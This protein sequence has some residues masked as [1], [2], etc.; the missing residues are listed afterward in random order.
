M[1]ANSYT[2]YMFDLVRRVVDEIGP[3]PP[4]SEEEKRL[5]RL[6]VD[7]WKPICHSVEVETF[8]CSPHAFLGFL[9]FSV[10]CY[11]VAVVLYWFYPPV[12]FA[13]AAIGIG[14][15]LLQLNYREFVDP[16]F[17][18]RQGENVIGAVRPEGEPGRRVIVCA[19]QDSAYEFN[20]FYYL[21]RAA[22]PVGLVA[23]VAVVIMLGGSLAKTVAYFGGSADATV[24]AV[25]G[26]VTVGLSPVVALFAFFHTY[27]PVPGA[28]DD[29]SGLAVMAGLGKYLDEAK[30]NG[31]W[32][33]ER[34]EVVLL[35]TS[36]EE[37]GLRGAKRY[38]TR[39]LEE[40][41]ATPTYGLFLECIYDEKFLTVAH[42]EIFTGAKHDPGLVRMAREVAAAHNWPIAVKAIPVGASDASAF[43]A[44][45]IPSICLL[46]QDISRP[47]PNYHTRNDTVDYMRPESL[48]VSLQMVIDMI[49]RIDGM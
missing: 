12:S 7:E 39:H 27:R 43:S 22:I 14:I 37:A 45:G 48:S 26:W 42:R 28:A 25:I 17:P 11:M 8:T 38:V 18:R 2:H 46:G 3:R 40:M 10:L 34:T 30:R 47:V 49:K 9:P 1:Q 4:C 21:G 15:L 19:H 41:R 24:F 31:E 35:A 36:S 32:V 33:P 13:L 44:K 5:G 23:L 16:L 6:L 20:F 29:M